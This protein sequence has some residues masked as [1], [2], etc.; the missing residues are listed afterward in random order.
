[1]SADSHCL[2]TFKVL[3]LFGLFATFVVMIGCGQTG[4]DGGSSDPDSTTSEKGIVVEVASVSRATISASYNGTATLEATGQAQVVAKASGVLLDVLTEE[5]QSVR[6]GQVLARIDPDQQRLEVARNEAMLRKLEAEFARSTE[7]F[8]RKLVA[9]DAHE[10]IRY[11]LAT[12]RAAW[13]IA[14]LQLSYTEIR[15]PIN[16]VVARR[17]VK[18]GNL[19][20]INDAL[21]EIVDIARLEAV[22]NV[23]EREL[24]NMSAGQ[25]VQLL[26]DA[27]PG[28]AFDG[29]IDRVSPVVD[30]TSGT[31][32]VVCAFS[33]ASGVLKP[34]MFGRIEVSFDERANALVVPREAVIE[35]E[36]DVAVFLDR[37]GTAIRTPIQP[38]HINAQSVEVLSGLAEGDR[39]VTKGKVSLRDGSR[40]SILGDAPESTPPE[41]GVVATQTN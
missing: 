4:S 18:K 7:L 17:M 26:V 1:M 37:D 20:K 10:R 6:V 22:L 2:R 29:A 12:Q 32:R 28:S 31:F 40:I 16:G 13:E 33:E 23:P 9:E 27:A 30:P 35:G 21:F 34:G 24:R 39:V 5:G 38:G 8:E 25:P 3:K 14:K 41:S 15:A 11:D 36:G 19:I